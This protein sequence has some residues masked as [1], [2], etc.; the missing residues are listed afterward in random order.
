[1]S[2]SRLPA[3]FAVCHFVP[4]VGFTDK[5]EEARLLEFHTNTML[6]IIFIA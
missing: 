5:Q 2:G 6:E 3:E 4:Q 1:M